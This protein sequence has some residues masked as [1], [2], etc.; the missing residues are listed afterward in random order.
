MKIIK[1]VK[2]K[3]LVLIREDSY[4]KMKEFLLIKE[5]QD[6][7][8]VDSFKAWYIENCRTSVKTSKTQFFGKSFIDL[9][10]TLKTS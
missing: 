1:Q 5:Y 4:L 9:L 8:R 3:T 2:R 10:H 7:F 6:S